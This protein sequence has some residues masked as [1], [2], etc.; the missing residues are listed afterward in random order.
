MAAQRMKLSHFKFD[1]PTEQIAQYPLDNRDDSRMMVVDRKTGKFE[2]KMFKDII[3][4]FDES[5]LGHFDEHSMVSIMESLRDRF[6]YKLSHAGPRRFAY[7]DL[8]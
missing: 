6:P 5:N 4:M 3:G 1:L 8:S 2:H 7:H